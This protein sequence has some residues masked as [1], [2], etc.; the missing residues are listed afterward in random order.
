[1]KVI[2]GLDWL[3][4]EIHYP[5]ELID[6]CIDNEPHL[7]GCDIVDYVYT[8]YKCSQQVDYRKKEINLIFNKLS[9]SLT[10]LYYFKEGGFS[11]FP[12][13]SQS[14]YYGLKITNSENTPDIHGTLLCLWALNMILDN[15]D[16]LSPE[17]KID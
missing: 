9:E 4:H 3:N 11:Y 14:H 1:M 13:K 10:D 12:K 2:T 16:M 5:K 15:L 17:K 7:E 8:L 6:F